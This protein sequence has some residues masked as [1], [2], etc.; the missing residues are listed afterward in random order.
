MK[1]KA[2]DLLIAEPFLGDK[3]FERAVLLVCEHNKYGSFGLVLNKKSEYLLSQ[4][5]ETES[6]FEVFVGGPV[7]KE[8]LHF[9]HRCPHLI[10]ESIDLGNDIFWSGNFETLLKLLNLNIIKDTEIR[11]FIGY[12]GWG[13]EQ[14]AGELAEKAWYISETTADDV[15]NTAA[16]EHWRTVLKNKGGVYKSIANYPL[17]P[18]LN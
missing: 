12:S 1:L 17:D 16:Q 14:L 10:D 2:G 13:P 15:F 11:F 4:L 9:I 3:H 5:I 7:Q 18:N 8:T 6:D